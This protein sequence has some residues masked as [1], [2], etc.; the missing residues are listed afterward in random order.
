MSVSY[1][2]CECL[3]IQHPLILILRINAKKSRI[4]SHGGYIF[5]FMMD[6]NIRSQSFFRT[7]FRRVNCVRDRITFVILVDITDLTIY[8]KLVDVNYSSRK[9]FFIDHTF[10]QCQNYYLSNKKNAIFWGHFSFFTFLF[11]SL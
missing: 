7:I 6:M 5:E 10:T 11:G 1:D 9:I 2:V 3:L 8:F 4:I